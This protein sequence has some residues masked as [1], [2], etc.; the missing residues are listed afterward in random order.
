MDFL[1]LTKKKKQPVFRKYPEIKKYRQLKQQIQ[2][3]QEENKTQAQQLQ[4]QKVNLQRRGIMSKEFKVPDY[5]IAH[6]RNMGHTQKHQ[7]NVRLPSIEKHKVQSQRK[8][9]LSLTKITHPK[10]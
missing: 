7:E 5:N 9:L 8:R 4:S 2:D 6:S 3:L 10:D 1:Q